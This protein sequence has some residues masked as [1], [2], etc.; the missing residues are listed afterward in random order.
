MPPN[1]IAI[2]LY[3][4]SKE[5][6]EQF[7]GNAEN[8]NMVMNSL[9][10][11]KKA[12]IHFVLRTVATKT[13]YNS[14]MQKKFHKIA[15]KFETSF[16]YDPIVFPMISGNTSPLNECLSALEI[17]QLEKISHERSN[18]WKKLILKDE[19]YHWTCNA[20]IC[21]L[22]IDYIGNAHVCGVY[23]EEPISILENN[24]DKVMEPLKNI[25]NKHLEIV[26]SN[27]CFFCENRIICKWCPAY[28][29]IY[30]GNNF[31][32]IKFFC[33]LAEKRRIT[34]GK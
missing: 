34:F 17:L 10:L 7:T 9:N 21:S 1:N 27:E 18:S 3:G 15:K 25:H 16:K 23:R 30:N 32:K 22:A 29:Q 20:G 11:L 2:T 26:N 28:S 24:M 19:T 8:Y 13:L 12:G 4:T 31:E 6:Y 14:L 33:D 5:E